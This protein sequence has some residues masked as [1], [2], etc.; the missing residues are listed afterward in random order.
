VL[1]QP[2][3]RH[4]YELVSG[5]HEAPAGTDEETK[6]LEFVVRANQ[7]V[8]EMPTHRILIGGK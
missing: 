8:V 7:R 3:G 6:L 2:I 5:P 1:E 4:Y